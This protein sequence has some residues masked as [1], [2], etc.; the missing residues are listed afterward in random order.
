MI[1]TP[2]Q[3]YLL[4]GGAA[5]LLW[6]SLYLHIRLRKLQQQSIEQQQQLAVARTQ[7]ARAADLDQQL[8][9][10][11]DLVEHLR[12][13]LN[14]L[15]VDL[16]IE[17]EKKQ[18]ESNNLS[19]LR[20]V[21]QQRETELSQLR[22]QLSAKQ[23]QVAELNTRL[24]EQQLQTAEKMQLLNDSRTELSNQFKTLAQEIFDEKL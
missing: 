9:A 21:V 15:N 13:Q 19:Q 22:S 18:S 24:E 17:N 14:Q 12:A 23:Q 1:F 11:R 6:R 3:I 10:A 2:V 4:A 7:G 16:A 5:L 8:T 20:T